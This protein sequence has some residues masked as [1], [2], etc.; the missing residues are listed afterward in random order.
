MRD[1]M[2][3]FIALVIVLLLDSLLVMLC[4]NE[5]LPYLFG[6]PKI[7]FLKSMVL[8]ILCNI[9]FKRRMLESDSNKNKN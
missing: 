2:I 5:L 9:L 7:S 8:V 6:L 4:W 3:G 1:L